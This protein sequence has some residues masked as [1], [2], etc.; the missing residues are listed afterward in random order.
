MPVLPYALPSAVMCAVRDVRAVA[1]PLFPSQVRE[2]VNDFYASRYT[3]CIRHLERLR[4]AWVTWVWCGCGAGVWGVGEGGGD[5]SVC[6]G[7]CVG[8]GGRG[9]GK[10]VGG[11]WVCLLRDGLLRGFV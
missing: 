6:G 9:W 5:G 10:G 4:W 8:V 2:A 11:E 1:P 7:W 3:D